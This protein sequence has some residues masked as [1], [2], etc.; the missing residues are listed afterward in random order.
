MCPGYNTSLI[1]SKYVGVSRQKFNE[2]LA[3]ALCRVVSTA[4][5]ALFQALYVMKSQKLEFKHRD[6]TKI[7]MHT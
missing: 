3:F 5:G 6:S 1:Q 4:D 2:D 7:E